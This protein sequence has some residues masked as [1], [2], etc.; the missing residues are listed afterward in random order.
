MLLFHPDF[1]QSIVLQP[2]VH[3]VY[4]AARVCCRASATPIAAELLK[5]HGITEKLRFKC[6]ERVPVALATALGSF[7]AI[8]DAGQLEGAR[9]NP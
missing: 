4:A 2:N 8:V 3:F 9:Y 5:P 6:N 1:Q 7:T